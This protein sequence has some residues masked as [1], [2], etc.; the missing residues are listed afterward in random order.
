MTEIAVRQSRPMPGRASLDR[1]AASSAWLAPCALFLIALGPRVWLAWSSGFD[2]LYGQDAYAYYDYARRMFAALSQAQMPPPFWWPLGYPALLSFGFLILGTSVRSAQIITLVSG[3][4]AAPLTFLLARE[5][6][7]GPR[8]NLAGLVAG[9]IVALGGQ[10]VQSSIVIMA[11][12]PAVIL[13]AFSAWLLLRYRRSGFVSTLALSAVGMAFAVITRW[14]NL[15]FAVVWL[16][17]TLAPRRHQTRKGSGASFVADMRNSASPLLISLGLAAI[18]SLPQLAYQFQNAAPFAGQSWLQGWSPANLYGRSFDTVDGHFNYALPVALF[19][20]QVIFHPAYLFPLLT[21]FLIVGAWLFAKRIRVDPGPF[22]IL[23]GW[24]GVF[25]LFLAGIP[26]ENFRFGLAFFVPAAVL[27]GAGVG[28][29][30]ERLT[31]RPSRVSPSVGGE[32]F[33]TRSHFALFALIVIAL[34]GM[35]GWEQR[36]LEPVLQQKQ[37]ELSDTQWLAA[38][39]PRSAVLYTFG[40]TEALNTYSTLGARDLSE[41]KPDRIVADF[42]ANPSSY[43]FVD[44]ANIETQWRGQLLEQNLHTLRDQAGLGELGKI[45]S[46]TLFLVGAA[47]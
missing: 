44:V 36:V 20:A 37:M 28:W 24:I 39:L 5:A 12:A 2:G 11:D 32:L 27:A 22:I 35:A 19:Y 6:M 10:L 15:G 29:T 13:T 43:L 4:L 25:Y 14:E 31:E 30:W 7:H 46:F 1:I 45:G 33:S 26:Y 16:G 42:K 3:A 17:A 34:I 8:A 47:P 41:E 38:R 40:V 23:V 21:P 9:A 18:V